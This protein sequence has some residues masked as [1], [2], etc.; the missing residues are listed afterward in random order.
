MVHRSNPSCYI[1]GR[2]IRKPMCGTGMGSVLLSKGGPG[3]G[4]SYDSVASYED[5]T[6]QSIR[7]GSV[8]SDKLSRLL[9]KPL[10]KK[11]QNIRF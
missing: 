9:V 4:S 5:A 1:T 3:G 2:M 8:L 6:G 10:V 7:G 11:P